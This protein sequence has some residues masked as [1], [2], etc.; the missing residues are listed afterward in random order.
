MAGPEI[1]PGTPAA[2]TFVFVFIYTFVFT[3][4]LLHKY[5]LKYISLKFNC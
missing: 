3:V 4:S 5:I 1:E 2:P